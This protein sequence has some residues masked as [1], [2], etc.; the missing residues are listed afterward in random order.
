MGLAKTLLFGT[1]WIRRAFRLGLTI[2]FFYSVYYSVMRVLKAQIAVTL[3]TKS[4]DYLM[5]PSVTM[6]PYFMKVPESAGTNLT[7]EYLN[8]EPMA[9]SILQLQHTFWDYAAQE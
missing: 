5:Y 1:D 4:E 3:T 6:C 9:E 7:E 2:W 8:I